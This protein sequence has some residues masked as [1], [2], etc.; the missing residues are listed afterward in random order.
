MTAYEKMK[1]ASNYWTPTLRKR[2]RSRPCEPCK[3]K[4][5]VSLH[6]MKRNILEDE[7]R[8]VKMPDR[9]RRQ[10]RSY[11]GKSTYQY[12]NNSPIANS[13]PPEQRQMV[14]RYVQVRKRKTNQVRLKS[15]DIT[16]QPRP[17]SLR[18][19]GHFEC[20]KGRFE[21]VSSNKQ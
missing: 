16:I 14:H 3:H 7:A 21:A 4:R 18:K 9:N 19:L 5:G 2:Q 20:C 10:H 11:R 8:E 15:Q 6:G 17:K 13:E 12:K 1:T